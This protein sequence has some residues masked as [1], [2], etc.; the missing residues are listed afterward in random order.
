MT[1]SGV[2][3]ASSAE[4][5]RLLLAGVLV[6]GDVV[7]RPMKPVSRGVAP[8]HF[9]VLVGPRE[10]VNLGLGG[11]MVEPVEVFASG[12]A[13][14]LFARG[15]RPADVVVRALRRIGERGTYHVV[16]HNCAHFV[17]WCLGD[18]AAAAA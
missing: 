15:R 12:A 7:G 10:V 6:V 17:N 9:G 4:L 5:D 18:V 1:P 8:W 2:M 11:V 16:R 14:R 13:V 3:F